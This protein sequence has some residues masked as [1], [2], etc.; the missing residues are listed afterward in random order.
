MSRGVVIWTQDAGVQSSCFQHSSHSHEYDGGE[1]ACTLGASP[2]PEE[3]SPHA[4]CP[5]SL[6]ATEVRLSGA[7]PRQCLETGIWRGTGAWGCCQSGDWPVCAGDWPASPCGLCWTMET[8]TMDSRMELP[9]K[10]KNRTTK[11]P[12]VS[13]LVVYPKEIKLLSW[14]ICTPVF[15]LTSNIQS[16]DSGLYPMWLGPFWLLPIISA[17]HR[18]P[19]PQ[20]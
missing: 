10:I 11:D 20:A 18:M 19:W 14:D 9:Q 17:N 6:P 4:G 15:I 12:A 1:A 16:T 8:W 2:I 3:S 13:F 7:P 5:W